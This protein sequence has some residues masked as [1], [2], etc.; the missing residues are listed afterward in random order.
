MVLVECRGVLV[1]VECLAVLVGLET[2]A[3]PVTIRSNAAIRTAYP[4]PTAIIASCRSAT[5]SRG[6][7][8]L[9]SAWMSTV[10]LVLDHPSLKPET[11]LSLSAGGVRVGGPGNR[12][13]PRQGHKALPIAAAASS[14]CWSSRWPYTSAVILIEV[15]PRILDTT[16]IGTPRASMID[17][18]ECRSS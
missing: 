16:S 7:N 9:D 11:P 8:L 12:I 5:R 10:A 2:A 15:C 6:R 14:C 18:V 17:V 13:T 3:H 1:L 4:R